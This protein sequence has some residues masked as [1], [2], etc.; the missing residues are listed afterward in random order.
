M[1]KN[2][3]APLGVTAAESAIDAGIQRKIHGSGMTT[4]IISNE[5]IN[6]MMKIIKTLEDS[7]VLLNGVTKTIENEAKQQ[8]V[9][10]LGMLLSTL[11]ASLLGKDIVRTGFDNKSLWF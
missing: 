1:I 7:R 4:L 8:K 5:E 3:F 10:F 9:G 6:D 2:I 11:D